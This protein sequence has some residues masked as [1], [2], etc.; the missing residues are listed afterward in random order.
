[1]T[2]PNNIKEDAIAI[3]QAGV[4]AVDARKLV[5]DFVR[6][7]EDQ[8]C[9]GDRAFRFNEIERVIVVGFGKASGAMAAG[10]EQALGQNLK[11]VVPVVGVVNVPDDQIIETQVIPVIGCRPPGKNLPTTRVIDGTARIVDF[12][13]SASEKDVCICLISGGGSALLELPVPPITLKQFRFATSFLSSAGATIYEL[14]AVRRAISQV[15]GGGLAR[16]SGGAPIISLII[17]DVIGDSL[18]VIAS[19]PTVVASNEINAIEVLKKYDLNRCELP[20]QIWEVVESKSSGIPSSDQ[21]ITVNHFIVGN[22]DTAIQAASRKAIDLGY[23]VDAMTVSGDEGDAGV[24]GQ[25]VASQ[26]R[27]SLN[28][29]GMRCNLAGGETTVSLCENP[30]RGGRNQHLVLSAISAIVESVSA[31]DEEFCLLS[32]GTDGEDGNVSVPGAVVDSKQ[33]FELSDAGIAEE[34]ADSL[35][36]C[37]S[38]QF[39]SKHEMLLP[40]QKTFTNVCDLRVALTCNSTKTEVH[41]R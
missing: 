1:M 17:S 40:N 19:G 16:F 26:I 12:V 35:R 3:W 34:I 2:P 8:L 41:P 6:V 15:K 23:T 10:F 39:L 38:N 33:I 4:A 32:G 24:I 36:R 18:E 29:P 14:N 28:T 11:S 30:G 22:I 20:A 13:R 27:H 31:F 7:S 25:T 9:I 5:R 37:D 21:R